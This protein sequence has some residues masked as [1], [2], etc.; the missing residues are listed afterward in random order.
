MRID[1]N[2][3]D[4]FD[5]GLFL[6]ALALFG[7]GLLAIYSSTINNTFAQE[8]F[9]R[10]IVWGVFAFII[11]FITYSLPTNVFK[12][13]A[14]PGYIVSLLLLVAVLGIGRQIS[15]SKSWLVIGAVGF[16]PS[17][18]AKIATIMAIAAYLSRNSSNIDSFKDILF[19]LIIGFTPVMLILLE[20]DMGTSIVFMGVILMMFFW[21]GISS[22][23]LFVVLSPAFVAIASIFG[24]VYFIIAMLLVIALLITFKRN[25]FFSAS[26]FA[27]GLAS[28]FFADYVYHALS[29]HQ[30]RRIQSFLDPNADPLGSGYNTIQ[31][32]VAIGSGGL[33][34]KGFL[35]GNQTQLQ[36]IPEQW[37]DFAF[38]V[39]GEEFGFIGSIIVISIFLILFLRILKLTF[40][41]KD[42]FLSL[43][44]IGILTVYLIH[45]II[46]LGMVVG[47]LPVIGIPLPFISYGGSSL[48]VNLFMLG[49]LANLYRTRKNYT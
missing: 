14:I 23:S 29:P 36:F 24:T 25:L 18:L 38:C 37:T 12:T 48:L 46:N 27:I 34:G 1:Y 3:K 20:P 13:L 39:I 42:E 30:Q 19:T 22:F 4:K 7:F 21:K 47:I 45:F 5:F 32:K 11:F 8:N 17:E 33:L 9:Q 6:P 10:Q 44:S 15:G 40:N 2:I 16:Q 31:A 35:S 28:G 43:V 49:I 41:T 26:I